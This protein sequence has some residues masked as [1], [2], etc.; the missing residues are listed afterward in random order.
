MAQ[1]ETWIAVPSGVPCEYGGESGG[2]LRS[3]VSRRYEAGRTGRRAGAGR[4]PAA[5]IVGIDDEPEI[6]GGSGKAARIRRGHA[7]QHQHAIG[8]RTNRT[9]A[10]PGGA[11]GQ[12]GKR[13]GLGM[14][15]GQ[16]DAER[17][18]G[19]ALRVASDHLRGRPR[20]G[21]WGRNDAEL[22]T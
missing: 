22:L 11:T 1:P 6:A 21:S 20:L 14:A 3:N 16:R 9:G 13:V 7:D 17:E 2:K 5:G 18:R 4:D 8:G 10:D 15:E 19:I 12:L